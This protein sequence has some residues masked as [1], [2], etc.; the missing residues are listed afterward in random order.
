MG[1]AIPNGRKYLLSY[2]QLSLLVLCVWACVRG[3]PMH[4]FE[5][6]LQIDKLFN[7]NFGMRTAARACI[8]GSHEN[9]IVYGNFEFAAYV[10]FDQSNGNT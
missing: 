5:I 1:I 6:V 10:I 9:G 8:C 4:R 3:A 7:T 2:L